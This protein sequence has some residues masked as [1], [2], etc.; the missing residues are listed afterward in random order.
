ML[1]P[2]QGDGR[3]AE[4]LPFFGG[5]SIWK[6]NPLIV[7]KLA[8]VGALLHTEKFTHSYM[9]CWRHKTPIIYRAT[10]QWF[11]GMDDT[12]GFNGRKPAESLRATA[13]RGIEAT[14]FYPAWG[15]ARLHGMIAHRPDWTLSRQ[16]QWGVPLPFF[17]DRE[18]DAAAS[19]HDGAARTRGVEGRA[20]RHRVVGRGDVRG[21]RRRPEEVPQAHRHARR[22]VR[23][24]RDVRDGDGRAGRPPHADGL[25]LAADGLPGRPLPRG[26]RP[27]SRLVPLVAA[28]VVHG[29]RRAAV[30]GAAHA[31]LRRR[32]RR[33]QDV[34]VEGQR[35]VAAEGVRLARRRDP[36]AVGRGDRLLGRAV[37]LRRDPEARRRELPPHPQHAAL[38]A[39][40]HVRLRSARATRC[41]SRSCSRSTGSRSRRRR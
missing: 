23:L 28:R 32:R 36:A 21:L 31:R 16:R 20:R 3:Y 2:V 18:T 9:H 12:P 15:K 29:Q 8:E 11:A 39:R 14:T 27:A 17:V 35:R 5:L 24:G 25:A 40:E 37:D 10:T 6:A 13:L 26:L 30:Q 33:P 1:N 4:S 22:V 38:P 41:R 34:E 19:G 7:A